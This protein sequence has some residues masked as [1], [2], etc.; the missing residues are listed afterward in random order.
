MTTCDPNTIYAWLM[1]GTNPATVDPFDAHVFGSVFALT[2]EEATAAGRPIIEVIGLDRHELVRLV[3]CVF[4]H[5]RIFIDE[6]VGCRP[7]LERS[8]DE[9]CL[10]ELLSRYTSD[11]SGFQLQ[12]SLIIARRAMRPNHLWQDLGL[13]DRKELS[14]LMMR[15][16]RRLSER[17]SGDM[18][19]KKYL[20]RMICRDEG[21]RLCTAPSC[22]ECDDFSDCFGTEAG[23][24]LLAH[25]R[26]QMEM[27]R[28]I[29]VQNS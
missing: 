8:D 18:K 13:R 16:F 3:E 11:G 23:E 24:S 29:E 21:F 10:G 9:R 28:N 17:N 5:A 19:W 27:D 26:R 6:I 25:N 7:D 12:L 20:Y 14:Q 1:G 4:P 2:W 15:H 22:A